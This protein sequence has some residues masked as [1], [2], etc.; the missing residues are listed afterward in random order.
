MGQPVMR[1]KAKDMEK[2]FV[3]RLRE[4]FAQASPSLSLLAGRGSG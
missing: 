1:S 2:K 3:S 4:R